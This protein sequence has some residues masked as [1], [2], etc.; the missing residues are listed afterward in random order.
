MINVRLY[1]E[2]IVPIF[3]IKHGQFAAVA[4]TRSGANKLLRK[5]WESFVNKRVVNKRDRI[6]LREHQKLS[7]L[8]ENLILNF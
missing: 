6:I 7:T 8:K 4:L 5:V 1:K 2:I 3:T